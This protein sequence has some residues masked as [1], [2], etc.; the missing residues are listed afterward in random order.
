MV[1]HSLLEKAEGKEVEAQN[2]DFFN[3]NVQVTCCNAFDG[4]L[5]L[6]TDEGELLIYQ[7]QIEVTVFLAF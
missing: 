3:S 5:V 6:G 1:Q 4:L 2:S 7:Q